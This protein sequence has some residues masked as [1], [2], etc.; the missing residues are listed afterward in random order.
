MMQTTGGYNLKRACLLF[1][2]C[3][4]LLPAATTAQAQKRRP[5]SKKSRTT[6]AGKAAALPEVRLGAE[7]VAEQIKVLSKFLYLLG[8]VSKGIEAADAAAQ[9]GEASQAVLDQTQR[10]KAT[11]RSSIRNL[12][13]VLDQLEIDF[14]LKPELQPYYTK[15]AGVAQGAATAEDEAAANQF[16]KAGRTLLTVINRLADVVVEMR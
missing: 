6:T 8:G 13:E 14:R 11:V 4:I 16:D 9:R 10:N 7:R 5:T 15:L 2:A 1:L 3:L 12:R